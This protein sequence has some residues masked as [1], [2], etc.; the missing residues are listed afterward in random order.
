MDIRGSNK[1]PMS[2]MGK[3][4][5]A[6]SKPLRR[7]KTGSKYVLGC[8]KRVSQFK[9]KFSSIVDDTINNNPRGSF[10]NHYKKVKRATR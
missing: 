6:K 2:L 3:F 9:A 7:P 10:E 4:I 5:I 1:P 8:E